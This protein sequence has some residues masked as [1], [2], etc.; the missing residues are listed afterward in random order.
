MPNSGAA[1]SAT[2]CCW[3]RLP[4]AVSH[5]APPAEPRSTRAALG[6]FS[7]PSIA[8]RDRR[9]R[10]ATKVRRQ[11][12]ILLSEGGLTAGAWRWGLAGHAPKRGR[13][14]N[15]AENDNGI[16]RSFVTCLV[17][18]ARGQ[19]RGCFCTYTQKGSTEDRLRG[20][21]RFLQAEGHTHC[22]VHTLVKGLPVRAPLLLQVGLSEN[23]KAK[24]SSRRRTA[25][26]MFAGLSSLGSVRSVAVVSFGKGRRNDRF[27]LSNR[28]AQHS[29][30]AYVPAS[31]DMTDMSIFSTDCT[32]DQRSSTFS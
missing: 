13:R 17:R 4:S 8:T 18:R 10:G 14:D 29:D 32:G 6:R 1:I 5:A 16:I 7:L 23:A 27:S 24:T 15:K 20:S 22:V 11:T 31:I 19:A 30:T 25:A 21:G 3:G 26:S 28:E 9:R 2:S 12:R